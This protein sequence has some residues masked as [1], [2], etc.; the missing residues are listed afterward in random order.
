[1]AD[2]SLKVPIVVEV[3]NLVER[4]HSFLELI[5]EELA[6][7]LKSED[8]EAVTGEASFYL[9]AGTDIVK[10]CAN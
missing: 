4:R 9:L 7:C 2:L 3:A 8:V 10:Q 1:M 5:N 6:F